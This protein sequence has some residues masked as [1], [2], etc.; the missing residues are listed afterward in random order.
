M[1]GLMG[2]GAAEQQE[3]EQQGQPEARY[4]G[5]QLP[6]AQFG[7]PLFGAP[8]PVK[9]TNGENG[10]AAKDETTTEAEPDWDLSEDTM[11]TAPGAIPLDEVVVRQQKLNAIPKIGDVY[12]VDGQPIKVSD[13]EMSSVGD[14][15][16]N[17]LNDPQGIYFSPAGTT[18]YGSKNKKYYL[19]FDE[20]KELRK[21]DPQT[22]NAPVLRKHGRTA[23][24]WWTADDNRAYNFS[25]VPTSQPTRYYG[26]RDS[27]IVID[28]NEVKKDILDRYELKSREVIIM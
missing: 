28:Q 6:K 12:Y 23:S 15:L 5:T 24:S 9:P 14:W 7:I 25:T 22:G 20:F 11:L 26:S 16:P 1:E 4:G 18:D 17:W 8:I 27:K 19:T 10:E 21:L 2:G 3:E 13:I